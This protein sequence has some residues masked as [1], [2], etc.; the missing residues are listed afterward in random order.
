MKQKW[1]YLVIAAGW[2]LS[3]IYEY[4]YR[5]DMLSMWL[6]GLVVVDAVLL[7]LWFWEGRKE[8]KGQGREPFTMSVYLGAVVVMVGLLVL[9]I[10]NRESQNPVHVMLLPL[11]ITLIAVYSY[12]AANAYKKGK[13]EKKDPKE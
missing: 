12:L 7:F 11:Y 3:M 8:R 4:I 10:F 9:A 5:P 2:T 6:I 1:N 13:S